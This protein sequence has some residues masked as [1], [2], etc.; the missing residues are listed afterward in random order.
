MKNK[1]QSLAVSLG[2]LAVSASA[3]TINYVADTSGTAYQTRGVATYDT[4]GG[5][6]SGM[7]VI[8]SFADGSTQTGTWLQ[9]AGNSGS[10]TANQ[11]TTVIPAQSFLMS[12]SS[13]TWGPSGSST[14]TTAADYVWTL[15]NLGSVA[16]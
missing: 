10:V 11:T 2:L 1:L 6:M 12:E 15:K 5:M 3:S 16:I 13:S 9:T 14:A 4:T 7:E 8:V